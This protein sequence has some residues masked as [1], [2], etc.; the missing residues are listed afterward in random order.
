MND[1]YMNLRTIVLFVKNPLFQNIIKNMRDHT[2]YTNFHKI[3]ILMKTENSRRKKTIIN[4]RSITDSLW[5][6]LYSRIWSICMGDHKLQCPQNTDPRLVRKQK[7]LGERT[8]RRT[9]F[10]RWHFRVWARVCL[11]PRLVSRTG[12]FRQKS[13]TYQCAKRR[14]FDGVPGKQDQNQF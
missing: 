11:D 8:I 4:P 14:Q 6:I 5:A 7:I 1:T 12:L 2:H 10:E 3:P 13:L 9:F